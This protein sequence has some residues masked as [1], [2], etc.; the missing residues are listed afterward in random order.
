MI[1]PSYNARRY[2]REAVT[3]ALEQVPLPY[4]VLVQ[5]GGSTDQTLDILESFGPRV[6]WVSAPDRG[7][8][9]ALNKAVARATGDVVIWLNADDRLVGGAFAAATDAFARDPEL[10][11]TYGHFDVIGGSGEILRRYESSPYSWARVFAEG[12]YI[13]SGSLF[14]RRDSLLAIGGFGVAFEACMDLDLMLRLARAGRSAHLGVTV[15]Q[16]RMHASNKSSLMRTRFLREAFSI[17]RRYAGR[18]TRLWL[19]A[20]RATL[21]MAAALVTSRLRYSSRWPRHGRGKTL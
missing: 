20:L 18:S 9:D 17:R 15:G 2:L 4:E 1:V 10:A 14:I 3:S 12:C 13:F 21:V 8:S 6:S 16:L 19:I 11:F 7:Q 5:D